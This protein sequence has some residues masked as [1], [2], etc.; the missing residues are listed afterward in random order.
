MNLERLIIEKIEDRILLGI[1][2][3]VS[4]MVIVGWIAIN[5]NARMA[6]FTQQFEGRAIERGA[7]LFNQNCSTCHGL[8]GRGLAGVAPA[9]NSPHL[10]GYDF[11]EVVRAEIET[12]E[13]RIVGEAEDGSPI[14]EE[15]VTAEEATTLTA[16]LAELQAQDQA[17]LAQ[18]APAVEKGYDPEKP[19][20][21]GQVG[22]S[23]TLN[24]YVYTTLVHGRPTSSSYWPQ[25]MA[26]W[27]QTAG[28]PLR[29]DQLEQLTAYILNWNRDW[30]IDDLLAV[31]QFAKV[32]ADPALVSANPGEPTVGTEVETILAELANYTGDPMN[33]QALYTTYAC[34]G[35]HMI[36]EGGAAPSPEVTWL[37]AQAG[38]DGRPSVDNPLG[39]I[40]E[41]I[42]LPNNYIVSGYVANVMPQ[43]F[44]ERLTYQDM[45]DITAYVMSFDS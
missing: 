22:W 13:K 25:A 14:F 24:S 11:R 12:I 36:G 28:G 43:N 1:I 35:C 18:L 4:I 7:G 40:V 6:A 31:N 32:P 29:D 34:A 19:T 23:G 15:S 16:R 44:G 37:A 45:A 9:L 30:T 10:F 2:S 27:S 3:F 21:L 33:G 26:A 17:I 41:S 42:V 39:Y 38:T 20:R 8:D 5:E